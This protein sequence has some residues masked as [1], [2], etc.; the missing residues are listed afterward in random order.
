MPDIGATEASRHFADLLDAV[1]ERGQRYTIVRR[2]RAVAQIG[3]VTR[4]RGADA[5]ALL[6]RHP[7]DSE[8]RQELQELRKLTQTEARF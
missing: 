1:E 8:W 5:K 6:R 2:G 7:Q 4:G 3:P